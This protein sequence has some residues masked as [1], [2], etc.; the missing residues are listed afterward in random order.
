MLVQIGSSS[1]KKVDFYQIAFLD[2]L[3]K[4]G[5]TI[6]AHIGF[7]YLFPGQSLKNSASNGTK[8]VFL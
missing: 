7:W 6:F 5:I 2:P 4:I 1:N 8:H 3:T